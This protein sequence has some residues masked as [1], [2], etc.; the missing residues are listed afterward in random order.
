MS[1]T[2]FN[3]TKKADEY[4]TDADFE[5]LF[6]KLAEEYKPATFTDFEEKI[7]E[8][9]GGKL[10]SQLARWTTKLAIDKTRVKDVFGK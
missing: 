3:F 9:F 8:L 5:K 10:N 2:I 1:N 7:H 6:I 4:K